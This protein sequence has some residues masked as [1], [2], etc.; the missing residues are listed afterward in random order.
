[1]G[2]SISNEEEVARQKKA[3]RILWVRNQ[4]AKG[5][6]G[7]RV[8]STKMEDP[9]GRVAWRQVWSADAW[10]VGSLADQLGDGLAV[11]DDRRRSAV[12]V[13]DEDA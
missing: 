8:K 3:Q 5:N 13:F 10:R 9:P 12:E 11:V 6:P 1:M 2:F 4:P 7:F